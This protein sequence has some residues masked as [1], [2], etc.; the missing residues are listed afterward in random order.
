MQTDD[1]SLSILTLFPRKINDNEVIREAVIEIRVLGSS[2]RNVKDK[3]FEAAAAITATMMIK[4]ST[5]HFI[6][7]Y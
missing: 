5:G 6:D 4:I 7:R 2:L 1:G 3:S